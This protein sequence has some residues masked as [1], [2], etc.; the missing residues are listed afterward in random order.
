MTVWPATMKYVP[1][2]PLTMRMAVNVAMSGATAVPMDG[3]NKKKM[4]IL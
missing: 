2:N 3:T 1:V 4:A